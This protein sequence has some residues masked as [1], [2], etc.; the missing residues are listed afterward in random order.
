M[1]AW[2]GHASSCLWGMVLWSSFPPCPQLI[3][4]SSPLNNQPST[5]FHVWDWATSSDTVASGTAP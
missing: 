2:P 4:A 3:I 1:R 5:V